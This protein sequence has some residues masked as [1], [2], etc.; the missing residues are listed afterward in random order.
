MAKKLTTTEHFEVSFAD[1]DGNRRVAL[2]HSDVQAMGLKAGF[3]EERQARLEIDPT[4]QGLEDV[5]IHKISTNREHVAL[6]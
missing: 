1:A 3:E 5:Q 4:F 6:G 2:A